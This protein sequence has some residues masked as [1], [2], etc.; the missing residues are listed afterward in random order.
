M[1]GREIDVGATSNGQIAVE[2]ELLA[3]VEFSSNKRNFRSAEEL[4]PGGC[5]D[6]WR[7]F[8]SVYWLRHAV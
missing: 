8:G 3:R 6:G 7:I 1:A 2:V 5:R 4:D